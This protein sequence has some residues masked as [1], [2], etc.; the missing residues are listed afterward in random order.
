MQIGASPALETVLLAPATVHLHHND[1]NEDLGIEAAKS[2]A[3]RCRLKGP[4]WNHLDGTEVETTNYTE[5]EV[6]QNSQ[7]KTSMCWIH[8]CESWCVRCVGC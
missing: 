4:S 5:I 7:M 3:S 1:Q 6:R 2:V 8:M